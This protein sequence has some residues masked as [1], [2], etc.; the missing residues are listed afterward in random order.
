PDIVHVHSLEGFGFD[1]IGA[2]KGTGVPV[3]I[4]PH[5]Y[6]W[7]CPQVDLLRHERQVC[8][9]Y[10][11]G[12]RC[13]GCLTEPNYAEELRSRRLRQT[14]RRIFGDGT[15]WRFGQAF[16]QLTRH[17]RSLGNGR[18]VPTVDAGGATNG[19]LAPPKIAASPPDQ[20]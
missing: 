19:A 20:N 8:E 13:V 5:N 17:L 7:L 15:A 16:G 9:D 2:I 14:G 10:E 4:T 12:K 11:G 1:L 6:Y 18:G 3:M